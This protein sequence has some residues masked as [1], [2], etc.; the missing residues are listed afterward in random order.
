MYFGDRK[1]CSKTVCSVIKEP[2]NKLTKTK[3]KNKK[4]Q[5]VQTNEKAEQNKLA[6]SKT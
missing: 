3:T 2:N 1:L 6:D 5:T 4:K